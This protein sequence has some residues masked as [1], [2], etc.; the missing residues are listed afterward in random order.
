LIQVNEQWVASLRVCDWMNV[1]IGGNLLRR[2]HMTALAGHQLA[3]QVGDGLASV[4]EGSRDRFIAEHM[5]PIEGTQQSEWW[6]ITVVPLNRPE[7]GAVVIHADIT[8]LRQAEVEAQRSRQELAHVS[9]VSTVGEMTASLAHQLNQP[10]AAIMTNAQVAQRILGVA[11]PD[12]HEIRAILQ[13]IVKDD[14]RASDVIQR[15]RTLLRKGELEMTS[16][17]LKM[18]IREVVDLISSEAIIRNTAVTL[19]FTREPVFVQ[20]DRVHLQ[21]V[22][23]NLL[24]NALEAMSDEREASRKICVECFPADDGHV[25]I[26][27]RDSGPGLRD[28]AEGLIF[29]PFYTTKA[30]GMGMGLSIVRSIVQAHGGRIHAA[31]HPGRGAVFEIL[32]PQR[33]DKAA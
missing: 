22:I 1:P 15:L 20:G 11:S 3:E 24:H 26:R 29:E 18:T 17:D 6:A 2:C 31:N 21:Q 30:G 33:S 4:L 12:L 7:Q 23:L 16:I 32:L 9:R 10:L 8:E 13:D 19:D 27:V 14:R 28:G 5:K 25:S